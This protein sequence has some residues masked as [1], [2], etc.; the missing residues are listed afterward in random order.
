[1]KVTVVGSHLCPDVL[2]SLNRLTEAKVK[3]EFKNISSSLVDLRFYLNLRENNP[4]YDDI[5]Y[6]S[7]LGI[8]CFILEDGTMTLELDE[9][10][11]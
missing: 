2:Y 7:K 6:T 9:V 11:K 5:R 1:M 10:L 8:P 3:I 4:L